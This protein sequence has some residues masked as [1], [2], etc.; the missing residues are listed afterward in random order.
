MQ[1]KISENLR[2]GIS[3]DQRTIPPIFTRDS[4]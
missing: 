3:G 1:R 4:P 2:Y